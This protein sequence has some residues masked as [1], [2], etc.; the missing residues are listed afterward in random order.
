MLSFLNFL[1]ERVVSIGLDKDNDHLRE[2][3]RSE[4]HDLLHKAYSHPSIGGYGGLKSG[5]K[6]ESDSIHHDISNSIIKATKRDGKITAVNLYKNQHGRKMI[7]AGSDGSERGKED[8]K[9]LSSEDHHQ[10]RS[11]GEVSGAVEKIMTKIGAPKISA[12]H[13]K[14]ILNKDVK[15]V[16]NDPHKYVRKIGDHDHEKT[17]MGHPKIDLH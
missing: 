13:A 14:K 6:E 10:K 5:S 2:K 15:P 16:P 4:I 17:I 3:H 1:E 9:K 11:W 8:W 12:T 7:A